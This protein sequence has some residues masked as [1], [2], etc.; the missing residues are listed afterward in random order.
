MI[1]KRNVASDKVCYWDFDAPIKRETPRDASAAA[2]IASAFL[3]LSTFAENGDRYFDYAE[4]ILKS[5]SSKKYLSEKGQ[6]KGFVLMHSVGS[7]PHGSEIDT[8][9]NYAD[10]YYLEALKRYNDLKK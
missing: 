4:E 10:Y 3:E 5:L 1:I 7:L 9:I 6:N 2:V 8:P